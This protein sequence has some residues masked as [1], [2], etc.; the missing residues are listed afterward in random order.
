MHKP[1]K[2]IVGMSPTAY[3]KHVGGKGEAADPVEN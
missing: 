3:L 2:R 1:F